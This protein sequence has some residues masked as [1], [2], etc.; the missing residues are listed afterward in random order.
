MGK[1]RSNRKA[2][3]VNLLAT[4]ALAGMMLSHRAGRWVK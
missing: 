4:A 3:G 2:R 1:T